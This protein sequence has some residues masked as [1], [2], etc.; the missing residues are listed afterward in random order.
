MVAGSA[1]ESFSGTVE[2]SSELGLPA[3][4]SMSGGSGA[5]GALELL[6]GE[7]T[8]RVFV[9]GADRA[10]VQILD[11]LAERDVILNGSEVW[12]YDSAEKS[13]QHI[14]VDAELSAQAEARMR[15]EA[16]G[17]TSTPASLATALLDEVAPTTDISVSD[18][19]RVAGRDAYQLTLT[20]STD[21]SLIGSVSLWVD[22]GTGLPLGVQ[23]TAAG[24]SS[25]AFTTVFDS[26]DFAAQDP[27]LFS[28][29]PPADTTVTEKAITA[30]DVAAAEAA[31]AAKAPVATSRAERATA[32]AFVGEGW[33]TIV[34]LPARD[35]GD[36]D[37]NS[38]STEDTAG[39]SPSELLD[40]ATTAVEGGRVLQTALVSILITDDGRVLVGAVGT[41]QLLAAAAR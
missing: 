19:A 36:A 26:I 22:S 21:G 27:A 17:I 20:P 5:S 8:T 29:T 41:E 6:T 11:Q 9:D 40:R 4:P 12:T 7:H 31:H 34:E 37:A 39:T 38:G 16:S 28:F 23:V 18:T 15:S 10:R 13:A 33:S 3:L 1:D 25:P 14:T 35:L 24:Q 2:Q 32:P 30:A